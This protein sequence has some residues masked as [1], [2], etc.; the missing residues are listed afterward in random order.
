MAMKRNQLKDPLRADRTTVGKGTEQNSYPEHL[1]HT[2]YL[3]SRRKFYF[4]HC[5][6]EQ[7]ELTGVTFE[8]VNIQ[9]Q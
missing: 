5:T 2:M 3:I 9:T 8:G 1:V 7:P 6:G 4:F